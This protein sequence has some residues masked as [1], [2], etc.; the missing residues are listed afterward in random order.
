MI[1][2]F[3]E[4]IA[5]HKDEVFKCYG[6]KK[7][8]FKNSCNGDEQSLEHIQLHD[9]ET[10]QKIYKDA[11]EKEKSKEEK[12]FKESTEVRL[13][14]QSKELQEIKE[15]MRQILLKGNTDKN[16]EENEENNSDQST[17]IIPK[18]SSEIN[19]VDQSSNFL[20]QQ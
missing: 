8:G 3:S 11:K 18:A 13:A 9:L 15:M 12:Q 4:W 17:T 14:E 7:T 5:N 1:L 16:R 6:E 20:I 19:A 10:A 2:E